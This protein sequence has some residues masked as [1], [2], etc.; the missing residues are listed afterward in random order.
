MVKC[1]IF[2]VLFQNTDSNFFYVKLTKHHT[3]LQ[4]LNTFVDFKK[5]IFD[6]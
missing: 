4:K 5:Y 3:E 2:S 6:L 1:T